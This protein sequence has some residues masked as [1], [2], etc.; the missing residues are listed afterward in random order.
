MSKIATG[1][2]EMIALKAINVPSLSLSC[3]QKKIITLKA[4]NAS[5][6]PPKQALFLT[7]RS[8]NLKDSTFC[9]C[10]SDDPDS[11][12]SPSEGDT[13]K[14][15]LLA[16]IAMLEAQKVR[17]TDY[18]DERSAYL[19]HLPKKPMLNSIELEKMLSKDSTKLV[20]G[21]VEF[22]YCL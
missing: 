14:Q 10:K 6:L 13:H 22:L 1:P 12:A 19:T 21:S 3:G 15:E 9:L 7:G 17:V 18:F 5:F 16:R 4:I 8:T 2:R 20:P 11:K